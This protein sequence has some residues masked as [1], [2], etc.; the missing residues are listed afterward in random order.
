VRSA[1]V[2]SVGLIAG[3]LLGFYV[4]DWI[5]V[6][7]MGI[8]H[9]EERERRIRKKIRLDR[10][11]TLKANMEPNKSGPSDDGNTSGVSALPP[12]HQRIEKLDPTADKQKSN[13]ASDK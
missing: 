1:M 7:R 6:N 3:G 13:S 4:V 9:D 5:K 10:E 11:R 12:S 8:T 2:V